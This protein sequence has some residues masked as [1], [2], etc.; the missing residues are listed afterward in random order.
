MK[1]NEIH[2][3]TNHA[4]NKN[5]EKH[6]LE[7]KIDSISW[8]LFFIMIG[9]LWLMPE[10]SVPEGTWLVGTA[11]IIFGSS[12]IHY[13][14]GLKVSGFWI[15]MGLIALGTGLSDI[16][17]VNIPVFPILIVIIGASIIVKPLLDK[18]KN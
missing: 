6:G 17:G 16:L 5:S 9:C 4:E 10:G 13:Y 18:R 11:I 7:K 1:K 14:N 2:K 15:V 3:T 8:A 12:L